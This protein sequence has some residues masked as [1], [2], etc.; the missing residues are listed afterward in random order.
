VSNYTA[1]RAVTETLK[2]LLEH[3]MEMNGIIV[4]SAPPDLEPTTKVKRI[5]LY[6]YKVVKNAYL[7]NQEIPG[8]GYPAAYGQPP[9]SLVLFY[10][11]TAFPD[12][13]KYNKDYD[14]AAHE[15][16]G[17]AMR[18]FHDYPIL[19]DSMEVPPGSG[20]KL[21]HTSLQN[22]FEKVKISLETL[23]TEELTKIWLGLNNP[24][25]LSV[26]Y[27]VSVVQI[28]SQK[29][30][31]I[32]RPVKTR[33]LHVMQLRRPQI[34]DLSV[35]P[36]GN[37]LEIPPATARIGD[38]LA[39]RGVNFK[40]LATKVVIGEAGIDVTPISDSVIEFVIPDDEKL[41]PGPTNVG[42]RIKQGT[43]VVKGGYD[44]LG[45]IEA[46]EHVV[47]SNQFALMLVPKITS[48][49]PTS[50][51]TSTT[52][53]IEGERLFEEGLKTFVLVGDVA[54]EVRKST[55]TDPWD[56]P[57]PTKVQVPLKALSGLP[58]GKY[59]IRVRV[60]GAE[61]L[62]DDKEFELT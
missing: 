5:N 40:A 47:T 38:T 60:N 12:R 52:L 21:L 2:S 59:P 50:G 32:A 14:L 37:G 44:D 4:S 9:L 27:A 25:R 53:T 3:Q 17:D 13:D 49:S 20:T 41:Q 56:K 45:E 8:E 46:G 26:G 43:E 24:Y 36:P 10:L 51:N 48:T 22:Q 35:T 11:M 57:T 33:R 16:L 7:N 15:I 29:P 62:E 23:D 34:Y 58:S 1:I 18:V 30:R 19:T 42:I 54:I 61:S 39:I 6:L 28:E 55:N 31:R